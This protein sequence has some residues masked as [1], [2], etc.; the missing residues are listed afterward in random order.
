MRLSLAALLLILVVSVAQAADPGEGTVSAASP[1]V[2]WKGQV[3]SAGVSSQAWAQDPTAPCQAPSCDTFALEVADSANLVLKLKGFKQNTAGGDPTCDFRVTDPAGEQTH[4]PG[5]CGPESEMRVTIKNAAKGKYTIDV[6]DSHVVGQPENYE[7]SATLAVPPPVVAPPASTPAPTTTAPPAPA[8][9]TVKAP[10]LSAK[11][12]KK[13]KKFVVTLTT[14]APLTAVNALLV[15]KK[16]SV[17]SGKLAQLN[18]TSKLTVKVKKALKKGT[19]QLS[20]GGRD[21]QGR[22]VLATAKV[23]IGK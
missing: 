21:A 11:K 1:T 19:Y 13:A 14:S 22:N 12:L 5:T 4:Y 3:V 9:L 20:V 15:D 16:K 18:G 6:A 10:K 17:G 2:A 23:K 7:A 8:K